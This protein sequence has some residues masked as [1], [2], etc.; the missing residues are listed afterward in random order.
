MTFHGNRFTAIPL[1]GTLQKDASGSLHGLAIALAAPGHWQPWGRFFEAVRT[2][3]PQTVPALGVYLWDYYKQEPE[4]GVLFTRAMHG[5]TSGIVQEVVRALGQYRLLFGD[6][7]PR[8][9]YA[10]IGANL[11]LIQAVA[12]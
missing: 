12:I 8:L 11:A 9:K 5:F 7:G 6:A 3:E 1:S 10:S 2:G 4:E